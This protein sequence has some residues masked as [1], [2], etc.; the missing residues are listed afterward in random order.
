[1]N[2]CPDGAIEPCR[3]DR[4]SNTV[5]LSGWLFLC[6]CMSVC[7]RK[8]CLLVGFCYTFL[9]FYVLWAM[10]VM[11]VKML[12]FTFI[13]GFFCSYSSL[14]QQWQLPNLKTQP[15]VNFAI[16]RRKTKPL[17]IKLFPSRLLLSWLSLSYASLS[18]VNW[19]Q[20]LNSVSKGQRSHVAYGVTWII[21]TLMV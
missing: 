7:E 9:C 2:S 12:N 5:Y 21:H 13:L 10:C 17:N 16:L 18:G 20:L 15:E 8:S 6:V 19:L 14:C 3:L 4:D 1:M 11:F